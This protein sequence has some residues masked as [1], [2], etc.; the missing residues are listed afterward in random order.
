MALFLFVAVF[1]GVSFNLTYLPSNETSN[2]VAVH[3]IGNALA[4]SMEDACDVY[5]YSDT[6]V[7]PSIPVIYDNGVSNLQESFCL[8]WTNSLCQF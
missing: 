1:A 7:V 6:E 8:F 3:Q 2:T 4:Q 5:G